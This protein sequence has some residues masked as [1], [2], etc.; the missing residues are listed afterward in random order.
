L[1]SPNSGYLT[2]N[3]STPT[4]ITSSGLSGIPVFTNAEIVI[5]KRH[6]I[7][8]RETVSSQSSTVVGFSNLNTVYSILT[9][10][11]FFFQNHINACTAQGDWTYN[12]VT[13]KITIYSVGTPSDVQVSNID[14]IVT[15]GAFSYTTFNN[16][17]FRGS[18]SKTISI[19]SGTHK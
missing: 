9:G 8:D 12:S 7:I 18:N 13:K 10:Y 15:I 2:I 17:Q 11:G 1:T 5:R 4:S 14:N 19:I 16:I 3:S 6:W